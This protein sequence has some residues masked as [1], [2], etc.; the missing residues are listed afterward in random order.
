M[1]ARYFVWAHGV[2]PMSGSGKKLVVGANPDLSGCPVAEWC[3]I[4]DG[5][6]I[7]HCEERSDVA[8]QPN[9]L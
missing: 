7:C 5:D 4:F 9:L 1:V 6:P 2:R 8:I 3:W